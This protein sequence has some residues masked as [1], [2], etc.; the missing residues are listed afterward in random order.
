MEY[1][2]QKAAGIRTDPPKSCLAGGPNRKA[3]NQLTNIRTDTQSTAPKGIQGPLTCT[4]TISEF[5]PR[6]K[7]N[8]I[9]PPEEPPHESKWFTGLS[10][11][12]MRLLTVSPSC[13]GELML[14]SMPEEL[15]HLC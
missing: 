14:E 4:A 7:E 11:R 5:E 1:I 10:V 13:R 6:N 9:T 2:P 15:T 12:P 3:F 8:I